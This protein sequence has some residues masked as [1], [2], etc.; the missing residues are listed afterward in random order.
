MGKTFMPLFYLFW[1]G[2]IIDRR[3][4][5]FIMLSEGFTENSIRNSKGSVNP[6]INWKDIANYEFLLPPK[7]QQAQ[8]AELLWAMDEV[9]ER[10]REVLIHLD[11]CFGVFRKGFIENGAHLKQP[12]KRIRFGYIKKEWPTRRLG[13]ICKLIGGNA[14]KSKDFQAK[15]KFQ[16]LRIGN[17]TDKGLDLSKSPVFLDDIKGSEKR[18]LIP[19]GS[20][21]LSLTGT[22]G[23]RDYGFPILMDQDRKYLLNQRLVMIQPIEE[24]ILPEFLYL[25]AKMEIFQ[26]RFFLNAIGSANQANVSTVDVADIEIPIPSLEEQREIVSKMTLIRS[27]IADNEQTTLNSKA[28]QKSLINEIF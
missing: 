7:D 18:Y 9:I 17:L 16:V 6:Y 21:I 24:F 10:E 27:G 12:S 20:I 14:F 13:E 15:G 22:N 23:K 3:L 4:L 5:P 8:L 2:V 11:V 1:T 26:G 28:L 25:T 19:K